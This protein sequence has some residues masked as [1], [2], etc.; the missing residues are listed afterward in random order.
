MLLG[1]SKDLQNRSTQSLMDNTNGNVGQTVS[2]GLVNFGQWTKSWST[3]PLKREAIMQTLPVMQSFFMFF[4]IILTPVILTFSGYSPKALGSLCGLFIMSIFLQYLWHL[5]GFEERGV[6]D[7]LGDNEAVSAMRN[8]AVMFYF[9]AP[10][11]LLKLSGHFGSEAGAGMSVLMG[12]ATEQSKDMAQSTQ[13]TV[14][15][16]KRVI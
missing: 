14:S 4:L 5:V 7:P 2:H 11:L 3:T 15:T 16:I 13:D 9:V 10:M 12:H 6:L 1:H 8:M